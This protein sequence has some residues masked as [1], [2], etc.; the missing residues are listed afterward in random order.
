MAN[1]NITTY[2]SDSLSKW[3]R[4]VRRHNNVNANTFFF[5]P[6]LY[7][8]QYSFNTNTNTQY[9]I[10]LAGGGGRHNNVFVNTNICFFQTPTQKQ[11]SFNTIIQI[12]IQK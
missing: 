7:N 1:T 5:S 3:T 10:Q 12:Q 11:Y 8:C 2:K 9:K 6:C 4:G